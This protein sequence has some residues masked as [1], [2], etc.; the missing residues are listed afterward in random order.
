MKSNQKQIEL[1]APA[2]SR[3]KLDF[4]FLYG[5]DSVYLGMP[6]FSLRAREN[7]FQIHEVKKAILKAKKYNKKIYLTMN[8][9]AHNIKIK[10]FLKA[11][12][13]IYK[14]NPDGFIMADP[15]LIHLVLQKY[16]KAIIHLSTQANNTNWAQVKFWESIGIK[17]IILA[18]ELNIDEIKEIRL[19]CP[20]IE[21]EVFIHG[22]MCVSY[23]GRCL[24]SNYLDYRDSNQGVCGHSCR[25]GYKI[26]KKN[27]TINNI[28]ESKL[29]DGEY[30]LEEVKRKGEFMPI[31][32]EVDGG[33]YI[34][35]SRD[36]CALAYIKDLIDIGIN[37]LKIE[38][39][40]KN[41]Y[42]L[43]IITRA[44]RKAIDDIYKGKQ[45]SDEIYDEVFSTSNRGFIPGFLGGSPKDKGIYYEKNESLQTHFF[46]GKVVKYNQ[47]TKLAEIEVK[48]RF[49]KGE[50]LE[51]IFPDRKK[52]FCM[53]VN[54]IYDLD[55]K[56]LDV[57]HAGHKN[58]FIYVDKYV[59]Q[60]TLIR[61]K[62]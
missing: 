49:S 52:D 23:S 60:F 27:T 12:D 43:A 45:I 11:F 51:F 20:N 56:S 21:L 13:E 16:P 15:G 48:Y 4:A 46:T 54:K 58:V 9:Y 19:K 25:W 31:G 7:T 59:D 14:L 26:Y 47:K 24:L 6:I 28:E 38:G 3:E 18:R 10:P 17:R 44:Y 1:L 30:F 32:E 42:Y 2:G 37:S 61:K 41:I 5:A 33:T 39:R 36:I 62:R 29:I 50:V 22:S 34:M 55:K 40:N 57:V 53:I 8:I 35:N